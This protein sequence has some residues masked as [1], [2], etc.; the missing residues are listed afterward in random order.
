[1]KKQIL[2][3]MTA[4]L[5]ALSACSGSSDAA[6][7]GQRQATYTIGLTYVPDV[8]FAPFY[9]AAE[10]G[11]FD[12]AGVDV[13]VRNHGAQ[14]SLLGALQSGDED[15]VFAGGDE[16]MQGRSTGIDVVNWATMYQQYPV[17]LIV[18][19]DSAIQSAADLP[20]HSVGLPGQYGEN[21]YALLAMMNAADLSD[22]DVDVRYIGYT[23]AAAL[24]SGE[25]DAVIGFINS[26][27]V[28]IENSGVKVRTIDMVDGGLPLVGVGLASLS[29]T[30]SGSKGDFLKILSALERAVNFCE[31]HPEEALNI[32]EKY[33]PALAEE[34]VR[35]TAAITLDETLQLYTGADVFG[36][37]NDAQWTAMAD[38]MQDNGLL[39]EAVPANEAYVALRD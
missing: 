35:A 17:T 31:E 37:Q 39:E 25:V 33:V 29:D 9:V 34:D 32:T 2:A 16:V 14:E 36:S 10:Q 12:D 18:P 11:Y 20:G 15:I 27:V 4:C 24:K 28:A 19:E 5:L 21:Y 6:S 38:F 8:Q 1:M 22:D 30:L 13:T 26:D 7:T 3:L 23:Q